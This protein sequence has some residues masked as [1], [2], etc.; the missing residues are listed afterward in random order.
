MLLTFIW[1][2]IFSVVTFESST[3]H[4]VLTSNYGEGVV[5]K[6]AEN[7]NQMSIYYLLLESKD[8]EKA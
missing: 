6:K 4:Y 7:V 2:L 1:L 3:T 8:R 5:G